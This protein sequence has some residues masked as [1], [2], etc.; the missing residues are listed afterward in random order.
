MGFLRTPAWLM[1]PLAVPFARRQR[2]YERESRLFPL[3]ME[4]IE[5]RLFAGTMVAPTPWGIAGPNIVAPAVHA[6]AK[7][8]ADAL[9]NGSRASMAP[10]FRSRIAPGMAAPVITSPAGSLVVPEEA[11]SSDPANQILDDMRHHRDGQDG[12]GSAIGGSLFSGEAGA[13][14][15]LLPAR[16]NEGAQQRT[17]D[18][19]IL[20]DIRSGHRGSAQHIGVPPLPSRPAGTYHRPTPRAVPPSNAPTITG[21]NAVYRY[22]N[23]QLSLSY[24]ATPDAVDINWG[25]GTID[26]FDGAPDTA[27]HAYS[28]ASSYQITA[29]ATYND[30]PD[31][32]TSSDPL[33]VEVDNGGT[34]PT[35]DGS[36]SVVGNNSYPYQISLSYSDPAP[37]VVD[38]DWG[39]GNVDHFDSG[40]QD[41][42]DHTYA[43]PGNYNISAT[44]T[45]NDDPDAT[46]L[47]GYASVDVE[48][49][50][51]TLTAPSQV[52][53]IEGSS[54][55]ISVPYREQPYNEGLG[56]GAMYF[57]TVSWGDGS[58]YTG[59]FGT[60]EEDTTDVGGTLEFQHTYA[61][62]GSY[63]VNVSVAN[64]D[65]PS[66]SFPVTI[67][68]GVQLSSPVTATADSLVVQGQNG[69]LTINVLANDG[70][71]A[72]GASVISATQASHGVVQV[73][74]ASSGLISYIPNTGFTGTDTFSYTI[75]DN[76]N[77][78][79]SA[80]VSVTTLPDG[81]PNISDRDSNG[82]QTYTLNNGFTV[83][84]NATFV[85]LATG[86]Y[87]AIFPQKTITI[88]ISFTDDKGYQSTGTKTV[89]QALDV[90]STRAAD[91]SWTYHE[92]L[93]LDST[94]SFSPITSF[95]T[96]QTDSGT[97]TYSFTATGI[98]STTLGFCLTAT[99]GYSI[100]GSSISPVVGGDLVTSWTQTGTHSSQISNVSGA[101][102][103]TQ[104]G[105]DIFTAT[106]SQPYQ[107]DITGGSITGVTQ[108]DFSSNDIYQYGQTTG[109]QTES[110][111]DHLY[112]S[113]TGSF[114][115]ALDGGSSVGT[116]NQNDDSVTTEQHTINYGF[117]DGSWV[118]VDGTG[119]V[120]ISANSHSDYSA[121]GTYAHTDSGASASG[122]SIANG[123]DD[124][125]QQYSAN[126]ELDANGE[127]ILV[128]GSGTSGDNGQD[129][130]SYSGNGTYSY[131]IDGG[132]VNGT[133]L[134][135]GSQTSS[136]QFGISSQVVAGV[137]VDT[138]TGT[139]TSSSNDDWSALGA[140][141]YNRTSEN[142]SDSGTTDSSDTGATSESAA[143]NTT[144]N[145]S[146]QFDLQPDGQWLMSSGTGTTTGTSQSDSGYTGAGTYSSTSDTASTSGTTAEDG[147]DTTNSQFVVNSQVVNGAWVD[148]GTG[149]G[150]DS[151]DNHFNYNGSGIYAVT[152]ATS[153]VSGTTTEFGNQDEAW[154]SSWGL[155]LANGDWVQTSG[156][157]SSGMSYSDGSSYTGN[158]NYATGDAIN[159]ESGTI[160][161]SG[162]TNDAGNY[163][164]TS[165]Y[166]GGQWVDSGSGWGSFDSTDL[167]AYTG[168][169][170][171]QADFDN[172]LMNGTTASHGQQSVD[173][174]YLWNSTLSPD[175]TWVM[176]SGSGSTV[177]TGS[178][179]SSNA[180][181]GTFTG[182]GT[183]TEDGQS[184]DSRGFEMD[185]VVSGGQ[186][187]NTG[188]SASGNSDSSGDNGWLNNQT[189]QNAWTDGYDSAIISGTGD[190]TGYIHW[191]TTSNWAGDLDAQGQLT[192]TS[193][194]IMSTGTSDIGWSYG[195][196]AN[197]GP[198]VV[199]PSGLT[200]P[201]GSVAESGQEDSSSNYQYYGNVVN[202][203]WV[204]TGIASSGLS[205]TQDLG[206]DS[207][208]ESYSTPT[209][210][211][212]IT[213]T[214]QASGDWNQSYQFD[215]AGVMAADGTW[216]YSGSGFQD[217]QSNSD[218][219]FTGGGTG[220]TQTHEQRSNSA[221]DG[222]DSA[223]S[224]W[225]RD[226]TSNNTFNENGD[227]SIHSHSHADW[228][229]DPSGQWQMTQSVYSDHG[230]YTDTYGNTFS[231]K[232]IRDDTRDHSYADGTYYNWDEPTTYT[233]TD[234]ISET[235]SFNY[236]RSVTST[237]LPDGSYDI[238]GSG[239]G[240]G[241][242]FGTAT[243]LFV[244]KDAID[245]TAIDSWEH[246]KNNASSGTDQSFNYTS[247][248]QQSYTNL[249]IT[250]SSTSSS[251]QQDSYH[252]DS[253]FTDDHG[254]VNGPDNVTSG[255]DNNDHSTS[256]TS[257]YSGFGYYFGGHG[258]P[259]M[260]YS[261]GGGANYGQA[262]GMEFAS[263]S[264]EGSGVVMADG[265]P[266]VPSGP[267]GAGVAFPSDPLHDMFPPSLASVMPSFPMH[268]DAGNR[269]PVCPMCVPH[270]FTPTAGPKIGATTK[271]SPTPAT[272][273]SA[274]VTG[275]PASV[276]PWWNRPISIEVVFVPAMKLDKGV[277]VAGLGLGNG[278]SQIGATVGEVVKLPFRAAD[279]GAR[280]LGSKGFL[281][282]WA[283][284]TL[285]GQVQHVFNEGYKGVLDD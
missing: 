76:N 71:P 171:Y 188:G 18:S 7:P 113:G 220:V 237:L 247:N 160:S 89:H 145:Y 250:G 58:T 8:V 277:D 33:A 215:A 214:Y 19:S 158:G 225:S 67:N 242:D 203:A 24:G 236:D 219:S 239:S 114:A 29:T 46:N 269:L 134:E 223:T 102:V 235:S 274:P 245:S 82:L 141:S 150:T 209:A 164:I 179:D 233:N 119:S 197:L 120:D 28:D 103:T 173:A 81:S 139:G 264:S 118:S 284:A 280:A 135:S 56:G 167:S 251:D 267:G 279:A 23:Y 52:H 64:A 22:G 226:Y 65:A 104:S 249:G 55:S 125:A 218:F 100:G 78:T 142:T 122:A 212:P 210:D 131:S 95:G 285:W 193:G 30:N 20:D 12:L 84:A 79:S 108:E 128:S 41:T 16:L 90:I 162:L 36:G 97:D 101:P 260:S 146:W 205:G 61:H 49:S 70:I 234:S 232:D 130:S 228:T 137:W 3:R 13:P 272:M 152:D 34:A 5:Q 240:A 266:D 109:T 268:A 4:S 45:Y 59:Y 57:G 93:T 37:D 96:T 25:D 159:G 50:V 213:G 163:G 43:S 126:F 10:V 211:G 172:V 257:G 17:Q 191:S 227:Q 278:I 248:W 161:A 115:D 88:P 148:S 259:A 275:R 168:T 204:W 156:D 14:Q 47:T 112:D 196:G 243:H 170:V 206:Y 73:I 157:A 176:S 1:R 39:D 192:Y 262:G 133:I 256:G 194:T 187:V 253:A 48:E 231:D 94:S 154:Q 144:S 40:E 53:G 201:T 117:I 60:V 21:S 54:L 124:F 85:P 200:V 238:S 83:D 178:K 217:S 222:W 121:N 80:Q 106:S 182:N 195:G 35:I 181:T 174:D 189:Y 6:A 166:T 132:R 252:I 281:P 26:H 42:A 186:W 68:Q 169:G 180:G 265:G 140:G 190:R 273:P 11:S 123:Q 151:G 138:G 254:W 136:F 198:T 31:A 165:T 129:D 230:Q 271:P 283:R 221:D 184:T 127:W 276:E 99:G 72:G 15:F 255:G 110:S 207:G 224:S 87:S 147:S 86:N 77:N 202:G 183:I 241:S 91:N 69:N 246:Y 51:M 105:T 149:S 116:V 199:T 270:R 261:L 107:T 282:D 74:N 38:V 62:P 258:G 229:L 143:D 2:N 216:S 153:L 175:G 44:A 27:D 92:T 244:T 208:V 9:V 75:R 111:T 263:V 63:T 66:V 98:G 32:D 155:S 185:A 177:G